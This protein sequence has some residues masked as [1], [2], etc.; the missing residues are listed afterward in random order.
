M[1]KEK[2]LKIAKEI[3]SDVYVDCQELVIDIYN[4]VEEVVFNDLAIEN[5]SLKQ[6]LENEEKNNISDYEAN[7][8]I[9]KNQEKHIKHLENIS[10]ELRAE[11]NLYQKEITV[12]RG[13]GIGIGISI[14]VMISTIII[15]IS[16]FF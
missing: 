2:A 10:C 1:T 9:I 8:A 15:L 12:E 3:D 11:R 4:N 14:G 13:K 7:R 16:R 6:Q 5:K